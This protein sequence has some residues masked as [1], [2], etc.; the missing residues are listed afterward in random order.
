MSGAVKVE[1]VLSGRLTASSRFRVLQYVDPLRKMGVRVTA[2]PPGINKYASLPDRWRRR[3]LVASVARPALRGI[4]V[5]SR[6]PATARSW[7]SDVTWLEREVLPGRVTLERFLHRPLLFDVDDAIWLIAEGYER[8]AR[9]IAAR[10]D[11]V[12]AGN[13]FLADWFARDARSVER[14]WTAVDTDR[15]RPRAAADPGPDGPFVVGWTGSGRTLQ[16]LMAIERSLARFLTSTPDARLVVMADVAPKFQDLPPERVEFVRWNPYDEARVVGGFDVGLMPLPDTDWA[17]GKCAFKLLQ[18]LS[19]EVPAVASPIGMNQQVL[20]MAE[21]GIAASSPDDWT[22]ALR[23]LHI[24]RECR[25]RLG[26]SGRKLV[27][28]S[29]SVKVVASQLADIFRRYS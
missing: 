18:Y 1:A 29:F 10:A 26:D 12:L 15:F 4:K 23:T 6:I 11:C 28:R 13:D 5:A 14:V 25:K 2:R 7:R 20:D 24:D 27:E 21:V 16:Y 8:M 9:E 3:A 17:R 22:E 19:C